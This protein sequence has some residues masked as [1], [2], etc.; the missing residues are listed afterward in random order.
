MPPL[1]STAPRY[2]AAPKTRA[3]DIE[4]MAGKH[5]QAYVDD[6]LDIKSIGR[7]N[8]APKGGE[9]AVKDMSEFFT[10]QLESSDLPEVAEAA[11]KKIHADYGHR[12][13]DLKP[14]VSSESDKE[15]QAA[16]VDLD[17]VEPYARPMLEFVAGAAQS[18]S[19]SR[20][21]AAILTMLKAIDSKLLA[22]LLVHRNH[23]LQAAA[24][25]RE[26]LVGEKL[27]ARLKQHGW[28]KT[29]FARLLKQGV[30]TAKVIQ[31][32][33]RAMILGLVCTRCV[34]PFVIF[35]GRR[36]GALAS[37][38]QQ[39]VAETTKL[40][41]AAT[42]RLF[43]KNYGPFCDALILA[44]NETLP[45][46]TAKELA[47]LPLQDRL[48]G[49]KQSRKSPSGSGKSYRSKAGRHSAPVM[50]QGAEF[51]NLMKQERKAVEAETVQSARPDDKVDYKARRDAAIDKFKSRHASDFANED[52]AI[53]FNSKLRAWKRYAGTVEVKDIALAMQQIHK[54]V[55]KDIARRR[56][57]ERD[58]PPVQSPGTRARRG[59]GEKT[60]GSS[61]A[62][63]S[64]SGAEPKLSRSNAEAFNKFVERRERKSSFERYPELLQN[65]KQSAV[66]WQNEGAGS[67]FILALK[68]IFEEELVKCAYQTYLLLG[69]SRTETFDDHLKR[70][71]DW[72][73]KKENV[74]KP[75]NLEQL[76]EIMSAIVPALTS[77]APTE[78]TRRAEAVTEKFLRRTEVAAELRD[79]APLKK[80]FLNDIRSWTRNGAFG[81][82][83]EFLVQQTY[84]HA[85]LSQ[86]QEKL[87][88][89]G[90]DGNLAGKLKLAGMQWWQDNEAK[91]LSTAV[92]DALF[93]TVKEQH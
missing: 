72:K 3:D 22:A 42:N 55:E 18:P 11:R 52:F 91:V 46:E 8:V 40:L 19:E 2:V 12:P 30:Y 45:Q 64:T 37:S 16:K 35:E 21:P 62:S 80:V 24:L 58:G 41:S 87:K 82:G 49:V 84:H 69:K 75:V 20:L 81:D 60:S 76:V 10:A 47:G 59:S 48:H 51:Q 93:I 33:R 70:V 74:G 4:R 50:P 32:T 90:V 5:V 85:L 43:S 6:G 23:Q 7:G 36:S 13:Q 88:A 71:N 38:G 89:D 53:A 29:D 61:T 27:D 34:T 57:A 86:Y 44:S 66:A 79:N 65:M 15:G 73:A 26:G 9:K 56:Q 83:P 78:F 67:S 68:R 14:K 92:L 17:L 63:T 31:T 28:S 1:T 54:D 39:D 77:I 25:E